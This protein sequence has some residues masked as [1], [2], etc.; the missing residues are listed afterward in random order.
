MT[1]PIQDKGFPL[2][3][4]VIT[5]KNEE[6]AIEKCIIS[7][8]D[9]SY[10]NFEV[11]YIDSNSTD[12][13]VKKALK[14]QDVSKGYMNCKRYLT[15][16]GD[17]KTP[18]GGRNYGV[19]LAKGEIIAFVD[20]DCFPERDW[21]EILIKYFS[22]NTMIVGG[23][24][25]HERS[26]CSKIGCAVLDVLETF[27]GS[28]GSSQF[29]KIKKP[30]YVNAIPACNLAIEKKLF[31]AVGGFNEE[32]RFNEDSDLCYRLRKAGHRILYLPQAKV[33]HV[34]GIRSYRD[35][36]RLFKEYGY[37]RGKNV[38]KYPWLLAKFNTFSIICTLFFLSLFA[39]AIL[40]TTTRTFFIWL[41]ILL[42]GVIFFASARIA[43]MKRSP[44]LFLLAPFI[45]LTIYMVY[46]IS[47]LFGYMIV[48]ANRIKRT[49]NSL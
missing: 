29:L 5:G 30:A 19:K 35:F 3:S 7:V 16:S 20:A 46:N 32:L 23:P 28:G 44:K 1:I 41:C 40:E 11:I 36:S 26:S 8:L 14:M 22:R 6:D 34:S 42:L 31:S 9:Q 21:L 12:G 13:T 47:F 39:T 18:G 10:P 48:T 17:S 49:T 24:N 33:N 45:Y 15:L 4:I 2:A 27:F 37:H 38:V 25:I 43:L